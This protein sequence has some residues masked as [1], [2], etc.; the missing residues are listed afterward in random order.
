M[1]RYSTYSTAAASIVVVESCT[2]FSIRST[3][4]HAAV[5]RPPVMP[6]SPAAARA[7]TAAAGRTTG[8]VCA[9]LAVAGS[10]PVR[11]VL[12]SSARLTRPGDRHSPLTCKSERPL[13]NEVASFIPPRNRP[14]TC[15]SPGRSYRTP[16]SRSGGPRRRRGRA[17]SPAPAPSLAAGRGAI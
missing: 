3:L 14:L 11:Q 1:V 7:V 16:Q 5:V 6:E 13:L 17:Q 4:Q 12:R 8:E 10:L 9:A 15:I 2:K